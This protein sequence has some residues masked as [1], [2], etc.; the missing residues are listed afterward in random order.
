MSYRFHPSDNILTIT[1]KKKENWNEL[2]LS[3]QLVFSSR[4]GNVIEENNIYFDFL[5]KRTCF[6]CWIL[7]YTY[8]NFV[9]LFFF[10]LDLC[11]LG[12]QVWLA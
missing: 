8:E 9:K 5:G 12:I 4:F 10:F 3:L 7:Q 1:K 6:Q 11:D 2:V